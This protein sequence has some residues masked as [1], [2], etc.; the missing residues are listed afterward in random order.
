MHCQP[1]VGPCDVLDPVHACWTTRQAIRCEGSDRL[2]LSLTAC[3][4]PTTPA[5]YW[6]YKQFGGSINSL[7]KKPRKAAA[8]AAP[9]QP[10]DDDEWVKGTQ[11]DIHKRK[12]AAAAAKTTKA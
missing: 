6:L 7:V 2:A 1:A 9:K 10:Q 11:Y 5:G 3:C 12:K 8:A 4:S